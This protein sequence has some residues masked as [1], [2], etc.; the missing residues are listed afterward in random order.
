MMRVVTFFESNILQVIGGLFLFTVFAFP[1]FS[2]AYPFGGSAS[3]VHRCYNRT[4]YV[5]LGPPR[6]G[7]F[8]WTSSTHSYAFGPPSHA[9]QWLLGL[10]GAPYIC[11]YTIVPIDVRAA[12]TIIMHGSSQ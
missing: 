10:A 12:D 9:G 11:L 8:V 4:I 1:L 7:I 6:G 5:V 2:Y 3:E